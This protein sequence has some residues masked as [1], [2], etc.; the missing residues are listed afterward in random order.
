MPVTT[1]CEK[2]FKSQ[3]WKYLTDII[4]IFPFVFRLYQI[5]L[6]LGSQTENKQILELNPLT[7][8]NDFSVQRLISALVIKIVYILRVRSH[9]FIFCLGAHLTPILHSYSESQ[10]DIKI[11]QN[12]DFH[13]NLSN[14]FLTLFQISG[15]QLAPDPNI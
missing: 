1:Y 14:I 11:E 7:C 2:Y 9:I 5:V 6:L 4:E 13:V 10:P 3:L 8:F 12:K 15:E